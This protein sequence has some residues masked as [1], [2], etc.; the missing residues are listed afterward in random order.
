MGNRRWYMWFPA[1]AGVLAVPLGFPY[2]LLDNTAVVLVLLFFVTL[3]LNTYMGP[4]L[5][6]AHALVPAS[7]RAMTS[8]VLF[9][10]LNMI[11][12]GL[13]PLTVGVLSDLY[14]ASLGTDSLR[15]AMLTVGLISALGILFFMLA[16]RNMESDIAKVKAI[17]DGD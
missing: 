3:C 7:M 13:G 2:L 17:A 4:V 16:A 6:T 12:L 14:Q 1:L 15:Y 11:G 8:A 10:I 5:A 9:F